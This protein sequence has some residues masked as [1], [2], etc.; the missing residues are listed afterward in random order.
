MRAVLA[1]IEASFTRW[2]SFRASWSRAVA[3]VI[4]GVPAM[5]LQVVLNL[6]LAP[7]RRLRTRVLSATFFTKTISSLLDLL[8]VLFNKEVALVDV[9]ELMAEV[10]GVRSF[11][12]IEVVLDGDP[13]LAR[14]LIRR[15]GKVEYRFGDGSV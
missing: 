3:K 5:K 1:V 13:K 6:G 7:C 15:H 11:V 14:R 12:G 9:V 2:S 8:A 10:D 4:P